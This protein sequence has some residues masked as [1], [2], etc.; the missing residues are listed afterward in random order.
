MIDQF[1]MKLFKGLFD[2]H[3]GMAILFRGA[4]QANKICRKWLVRSPELLQMPWFKSI[5]V[6]VEVLMQKEQSVF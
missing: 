2:A 6:A 5:I 4:N 1:D 3:K